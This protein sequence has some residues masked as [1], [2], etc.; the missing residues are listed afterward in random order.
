M[1]DPLNI[2]DF[3]RS[4][5]QLEELLLFG[6]AVAGK[7]ALTVA[8]SLDNFIQY[9]YREK[10][11]TTPFEIINNI[12]SHQLSFILKGFGVGCY[13]Y[14]ADYFKSASSMGLD[15]YKCSIDDLVSI[16]GVAYKTAN[17]FLLHSREGYVGACLDVHIL[18]YLSQL[19]YAVPKST[20]QSKK[21]YK[22]LEAI[23]LKICEQQNVA[24]AILDLKL[25]REFSKNG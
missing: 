19:G 14:K 25:W 20:P 24:P 10:L 1:I 15:L 18:R 7:R 23:F 9:G 2:T 4:S 16:K 17:L 5:N 11:G 6:I 21:K 3:T 13:S 22:E 8:K 12:S